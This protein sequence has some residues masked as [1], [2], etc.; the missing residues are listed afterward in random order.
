MKR[1]LSQVRELLSQLIL[2]TL[3]LLAALLLCLL[4]LIASF[5]IFAP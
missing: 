4:Y 2:T 1:H 5:V 3:Y